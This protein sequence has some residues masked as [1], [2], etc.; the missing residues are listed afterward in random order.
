MNL[1]KSLPSKLA[2]VAGVLMFVSGFTSEAK[3]ISY[4]LNC[5]TAGTTCTSSIQWGT[6]TYTQN[7]N[8]VDVTIDLE[9][10][11]KILQVGLNTANTTGTY[12]TVG[13]T[14]GVEE[15][16]NSGQVQGSGSYVGRFDLLIPDPPPGNVGENVATFTI[17]WSGGALNV[18]DLALQKDT[19][20]LLFAAVHIGN[21]DSA[22]T[23][24][25]NGSIQVGTGVPEPASLLLLGLGLAGIGL[26]RRNSIKA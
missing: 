8:N 11:Y 20:N 15:S 26:W 17:S 24:C 23:N 16:F 3:A 19:N 5:T 7:G 1:R 21:C 6:I 18:N 12:D 2:A 13:S 14:L 25:P 10:D 4:D 9:D 22:A